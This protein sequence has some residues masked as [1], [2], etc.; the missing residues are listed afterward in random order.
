MVSL[1]SIL[2][3][4][5][6]FSLPSITLARR[7]ENFLGK[8]R[9]CEKLLV[10]TLLRMH[11]VIPCDITSYRRIYLLASLSDCMCV[12]TAVFHSLFLS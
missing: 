10:K 6:H 7:T 9:Q 2:L 11:V 12:R 3:I 1:Y 5:F 8:I 4:L